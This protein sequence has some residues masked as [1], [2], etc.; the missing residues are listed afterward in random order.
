METLLQVL[1]SLVSLDVVKSRRTCREWNQVLDENQSCWKE[2]VLPQMSLLDTQ[3]AVALF[4]SK[5]GS[6]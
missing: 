3:V 1:K 6:R 2:I 4:D 5:S